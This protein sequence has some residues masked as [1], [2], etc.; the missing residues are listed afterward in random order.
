M[1]A[2]PKTALRGRASRYASDAFVAHCAVSQHRVIAPVRGR[3]VVM[4]SP[5]PR[6]VGTCRCRWARSPRNQ[7]LPTTRAN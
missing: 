6:S 1:R 5:A 4:S 2:T 3:R 7:Q